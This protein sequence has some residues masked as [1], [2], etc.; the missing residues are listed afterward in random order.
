MSQPHREAFVSPRKTSGSPPSDGHHEVG[1]RDVRRPD[2]G[3][4][5]RLRCVGAG[6][7]GEVY[8]ARDRVTGDEVALKVLTHP[9]PELAARLEREARMLRAIDHPGVVGYVAHFVDVRFA[10]R[11]AP[12]AGDGVAL[13]V[14]ECWLAME[15]LEGMDL[16]ARLD[17]DMT[18]S[19]RAAIRLAEAL[20]E[21]L[22]AIHV[23]G[24]V[25]RDVK[26]ANIFLRA[27]DPARP[28]LIDFGVA[29][30][31][32]DE[33]LTMV[34]AI[35]GTPSYMAPEQARGDRS[36]DGRVDLFAM[37]AVL[38]ECVAGR[39]PFVG[40]TILSTLSH[41]LASEP[42]W[43]L[44]DRAPVVYRTIV[45][46]LL[47]K[48]RDERPSDGADAARFVRNQWRR[49][50]R[51]FGPVDVPARRSQRAA[52]PQLRLVDPTA[53]NGGAWS[54]GGSK[55]RTSV[56]ARRW[57]LACDA[58]GVL[59]IADAGK[60]ARLRGWVSVW[61]GDFSRAL[62]DATASLQGVTVG[63]PEWFESMTLM[64]VAA[65]RVG[66]GQ[67]LADAAESI[68]ACPVAT[69]EAAS[70]RVMALARSAT[71]LVNAGRVDA[72]E[73]SFEALD[74]ALVDA[75]VDPRA[76]AFAAQARSSKA[77]SVG[78][79]DRALCF[80]AEASSAF[81]ECGDVERAA[82]ARA[83]S[84]YL[85][86][87][88]GQQ[89]SAI[90]CLVE[91][92]AEAKATGQPLVAALAGHNLGIAYSR[93]GQHDRAREVERSAVDWLHQRGDQRLLTASLTYLAEIEQRAGRLDA[94]LGAARN[95]TATAAQ[96]LG[97][98][99]LATTRLAS[100]LAARGDLRA[101]Q[102]ALNDADPGRAGVDLHGALH[103]AVSIGL[104]FD[105]GRLQLAKH[106]TRRATRQ[107]VTSARKINNLQQRESYLRG[108]P[109]H[110][111][112]L[113]RARTL[114]VPTVIPRSR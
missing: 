61:A 12:E 102:D 51:R 65:R 50:T 103:A 111:A 91:V 19:S 33:R 31:A 48:S 57:Q 112:I 76:L 83:N 38:F 110:R 54:E 18:L 114:G 109:A 34:D 97:V 95:A 80:D 3:R 60:V 46:T 73:L 8:H 98:H 40:S 9:T 77:L 74:A 56:G 42:D 21:A 36:C 10:G 27:G 2:S 4:F 81:A 100:V 99:D 82:H 78:E 41:I 23:A 89:R 72:A 14:G 94:A 101:A 37:G 35:V 105:H 26:P 29:Y 17:R 75:P 71:Q 88:L 93:I 55:R 32:D 84:G 70:A 13:S 68:R 44:L 96:A 59:N 24:L 69:E 47:A 45:Q 107:L 30:N 66:V 20:G 6:A 106:L 15:W 113:K 67:A 11:A 108:V 39:P 28:C 104:A 16:E 43:S 52:S 86:L 7:H 87:A 1:G 62:E 25:H 90:H 53:M 49:H 79:L 92:L 85:Y 5:E 63:R 64:A 58:R 22:G